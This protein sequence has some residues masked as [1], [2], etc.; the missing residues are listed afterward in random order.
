MALRLFC[1]TWIVVS[2][3]GLSPLQGNALSGIEGEPTVRLVTPNGKEILNPGMT[4]VIT[5]T[6]EA[7]HPG[8][9][10]ALILYDRGVNALTITS[11][12]QNN[13]KYDWKIPVSVKPGNHYRIRIRWVRKPAVNDF[14]DGDFSIQPVNP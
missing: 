4:A 10:I 6:S 5:W 11:G 12:C 7:I 9:R 13:E 1:M 3:T 14:S 8:E 2:L